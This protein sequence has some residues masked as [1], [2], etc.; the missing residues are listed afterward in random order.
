[1]KTTKKTQFTKFIAGKKVPSTRQNIRV[2]T[3]L[4][5]IFQVEKGKFS[6]E[7]LQKM[8]LPMLQ[9]QLKESDYD[10]INVDID[11]VDE[12]GSC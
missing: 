3:T 11:E 7:E 9:S 5:V 12:D 10:D 8:A 6:D 1:M 2:E 4:S